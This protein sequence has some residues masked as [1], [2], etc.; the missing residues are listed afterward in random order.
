M[1]IYTDM[2][3]L[4]KFEGYIEPEYKEVEYQTLINWLNDTERTLIDNHWYVKLTG[5][6]GPDWKQIADW[7]RT[8]NSRVIEM[9]KSERDGIYR[10]VIGMNHD[11]WFYVAWYGK[12]ISNE[13]YYICDQ[14]EGLKKCLKDKNIIQ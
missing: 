10:V 6:F 1:F 3:H 5:L 12:P 7:R 8:Q 14:F 9:E 11:E 4:K 2:K 13:W